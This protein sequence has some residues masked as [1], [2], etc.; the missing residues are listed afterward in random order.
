MNPLLFADNHFLLANARIA[1]FPII[2]AS[3]GF[4]QLT[5]FSKIELLHQSAVCR[6]MHGE[7]TDAETVK[8]LWDAL[9][10]QTQH[11]VEVLLYKKNSYV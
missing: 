5:G 8:R 3:D 1:D 11:Q 2:F 6:F 10:Q 9:D 4:C 7:L